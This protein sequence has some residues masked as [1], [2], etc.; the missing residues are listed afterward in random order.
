MFAETFVTLLSTAFRAFN[1]E[2]RE[3]RPRRSRRKS[4]NPTYFWWL[5]STF[6]VPTHVL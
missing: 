3:E 1:R 5:A 4:N 2:G 6:N